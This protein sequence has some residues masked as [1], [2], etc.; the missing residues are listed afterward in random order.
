MAA[1]A[2]ITVT[3]PGDVVEEID[4]REKNRSRFVLKA[5]QRELEQRRREE[6]RRSLENPHP[7]SD[8]FGETGFDEWAESLPHESASDLVDLTAGSPVRWVPGEGWIEGEE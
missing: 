5:V 6:L 3:L 2:R 4:R 7:E 1:K 8:Q